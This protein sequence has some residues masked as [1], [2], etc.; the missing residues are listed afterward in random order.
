LQGFVVGKLPLCLAGLFVLGKI[1][2][3]ALRSFLKFATITKRKALNFVILSEAKYP[4]QQNKISPQNLH[5][6]LKNLAF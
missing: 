6:V 5:F 2:R 4:K 3:F 1:Y